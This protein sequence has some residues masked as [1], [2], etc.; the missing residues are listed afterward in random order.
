M[1]KATRN[2]DEIKKL[3]YA[4]NNMKNNL[5]NAYRQSNQEINEQVWRRL[6]PILEEYGKKRGLHLLLGANGMGSVLYNDDYYDMTNDLINYVD[7]KYEIG[8]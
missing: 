7:K 8:N 3:A 2:E 4:Y 6:N 5:E 1:A